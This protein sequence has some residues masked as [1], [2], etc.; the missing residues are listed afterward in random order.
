MKEDKFKREQDKNFDRID[1]LI[2]QNEN[3]GNKL[4][5]RLQKR[6]KLEQ[7]EIESQIKTGVVNKPAKIGRWK[8]KQRKDD[9]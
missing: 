5:K 3:E 6:T 8:Y 4:K 2:K 9:F 7:Q 1:N